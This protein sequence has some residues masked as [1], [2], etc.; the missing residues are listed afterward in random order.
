M[1]IWLQRFRNYRYILFL[2][3]MRVVNKKDVPSMEHTKTNK[4]FGLKYLAPFDGQQITKVIP[5]RPSS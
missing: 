4:C 5:F 3:L 1:S 2:Y